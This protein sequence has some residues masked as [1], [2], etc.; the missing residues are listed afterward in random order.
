MSVKYKSKGEGATVSKV[1]SGAEIEKKHATNAVATD[2][3]VVGFR[4]AH[5]MNLGNYE[6]AKFEVWLALP[7]TVAKMDSDFEVCMN[8][9]DKKLAA[10]VAEAKEEVE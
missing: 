10:V 8:W 3:T 1:A 5:T 4:V 7:S 9:A 2:G 6:S